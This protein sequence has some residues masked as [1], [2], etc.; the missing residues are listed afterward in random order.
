MSHIT[1]LRLAEVRAYLD[2]HRTTNPE[3][4]AAG[5]AY[6]DHAMVV[7][8][9]HPWTR[10]SLIWSELAAAETRRLVFTARLDAA[11]RALLDL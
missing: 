8:G 3:A 1:E 10:E 9:F 11:E 2:L 5:E 4:Y 7:E 6:A